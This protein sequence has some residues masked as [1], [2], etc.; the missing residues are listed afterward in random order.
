MVAAALASLAFAAA[1]SAEFEGRVALAV[2]GAP[3][4]GAEVQVLGSS[5][6]A[7]TDAE[8]RFTWRPDPPTPFHILVVLADGRYTEPIFVETLDGG[9]LELS[10]RPIAVTESVTIT[11]AAPHT[12]ATPV[13]APAVVSGEILR[14]RQAPRLADVLE[15]V[16]GGGRTSDVHAGT[17]TIRG[18]ARGRTVLLLDGGR[19]LTERRAGASAAFLDPFFLEAVEVVRGPASVGYGSDAFGG[20]I[21][22]RTRRPSP[23]AAFGARARVTLGAGLPEAS[24]GAEVSGSFLDTGLLVQARRRVFS[25]YRSPE[26]VVAGS[27]A[28]DHGFLLRGARDVAG[29]LLSLGLSI[30]SAR[31]VGRPRRSASFTSYPNEDSSRLTLD[32]RL[33]PRWGFARLDATLFFG[34]HTLITRRVSGDGRDHAESGVRANDFMFRARGVRPLGEGRLEVG[35]EMLSRYGLRTATQIFTGRLFPI[36]VDVPP[37]GSSLDGASRQDLAVYGHAENPV[38]E[39]GALS[40]GARLSTIRANSDVPGLAVGE[41]PEETAHGDL[42]GFVAG[43]AELSRGLT[44]A[45]QLSRGFRDPTLSDRYYAGLSGRGLVFGNPKLR[46]EHSRQTD[47][48]LRYRSGRMRLGLYAFRYRIVDLIERYET[49]LQPDLFFFRNRGEARISGVELEMQADEIR[50]RLSV[51][52]AAGLMRGSAEDDSPLDDVPAA[53]LRVAVRR[54]F[55]TSSFAELVLFAFAADDRPG[56]TESAVSG[57][58]RVDAAVGLPIAGG[59]EFRLSGRNLFDQ[60]YPV[61]ADSRAVLAPGRSVVGTIVWT[62]DDD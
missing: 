18:L 7:R 48:S 14:S 59:A 16:P 45:L 23:D 11:A 22:A 17:P 47:A 53:N 25:P 32:Y 4:A 55:G 40:A 56:P 62:L 52:I 2:S 20:V 36:A 46:P 30:D 38:G 49:G 19:V 3:A 27:G 29:G 9:T 5:G 33:P 15:M 8:G 43:R 50:E 10:V 24:L 6:S 41:E 12:D 37:I 39:W 58:F 1:A 51:D 31:D 44:A 28:A 61:S 26:G 34:G 57:Y 60:A 35:A 13:S 42:S 21:H 54:R